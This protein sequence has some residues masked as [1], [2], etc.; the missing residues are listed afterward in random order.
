[1]KGYTLLETLLAVFIVSIIILVLMGYLNFINKTM[2]HIHKHQ[3]Q[4][5]KAVTAKHLL[6]TPLENAGFTGCINHLQ[7]K[8]HPFWQIKQQ[9]N[10]TINVI[11]VSHLWPLSLTDITGDRIQIH[12]IHPR[13][14]ESDQLILTDCQHQSIWLTVS[15][16]SVDFNHKRQ[17]I[18]IQN[19][20]QLDQKQ[21]HLYLW[22]TIQLSVESSHVMDGNGLYRQVN[23]GQHKEILP[24]INRITGQCLGRSQNWQ[25]CKHFKK[26]TSIRAIRLNLAL[27]ASNQPST[28]KSR[29]IQIK[30]TIHGY[31]KTISQ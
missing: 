14:Y 6:Q 19:A 30:S 21:L 31:D 9:N 10:G 28:M 16:V 18:I 22:Q 23:N 27:R 25:A 12:Q 13:I 4:W 3:Q 15:H 17:I 11:E 26:L 1:M 2:T 20:P 24:G 29:H 8:P 7:H 5:R